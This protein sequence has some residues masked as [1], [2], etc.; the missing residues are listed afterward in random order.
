[1]KPKPSTSSPRRIVTRPSE[2]PEALNR[3]PLN[4][5]PQNPVTLNPKPKHPKPETL[6]LPALMEWRPGYACAWLLVVFLSCGG[7]AGPTGPTQQA[8]ARQLAEAATESGTPA[9]RQP[10]D[11]P[12]RHGYDNLDEEQLRRQIRHRLGETPRAAP[13]EGSG[14][15]ERPG[16]PLADLLPGGLHPELPEAPVRAQRRRRARCQLPEQWGVES[17]VVTEEMCTT[18]PELP[19]VGWRAHTT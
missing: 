4:P 12:P 7:T 16:C 1:M 3:S 17:Q 5:M 11:H 8:G 2:H 18:E 14:R 6:S 19:P 10:P 9:A 13:P 15:E